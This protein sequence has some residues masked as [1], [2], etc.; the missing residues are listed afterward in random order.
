[1]GSEAIPLQS[2]WY[3]QRRDCSLGEQPMHPSLSKRQLWACKKQENVVPCK[4]EYQ[5]LGEYR[6]GDIGTGLSPSHFSLLMNVPCG[7]WAT[8][9]FICSY[10]LLTVLAPL[11]SEIY[12]LGLNATNDI[13]LPIETQCKL[14]TQDFLQKQERT[15]QPLWFAVAIWFLF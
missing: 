6:K 2:K 8:G 11:K 1:M 12:S 15:P 13:H 9:T 5:K 7:Y 4:T 10:V 14:Q 3:G